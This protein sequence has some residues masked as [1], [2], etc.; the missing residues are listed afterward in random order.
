MSDKAWGERVGLAPAAANDAETYEAWKASKTGLTRDVKFVPA[1]GSG[2][3]IRYVPY[4]QSISLEL[5]DTATELAVMCHSSG[6]LIFIE[7]AGLDAVADV[8]SEKKATSLHVWSATDGA[9]PETV[10]TSAAFNT[11]LRDLAAP[12]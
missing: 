2:E 11:S 6:E 5:N 7:G 1:A 3:S 8:I 9:K 12:E 10:I 4:L